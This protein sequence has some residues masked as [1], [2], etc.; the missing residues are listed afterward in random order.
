MSFGLCPTWCKRSFWCWKAM[1]QSTSYLLLAFEQCCTQQTVAS[2]TGFALQYCFRLVKS[3]LIQ[4]L[5]WAWSMKSLHTR[6]WALDVDV[7]SEQKQQTATFDERQK[8]IFIHC[9]IDMLHHNFCIP[10]QIWRPLEPYISIYIQ[11]L[12]YKMMMPFASFPFCHRSTHTQYASSS[13]F[14]ELLWLCRLFWTILLIFKIHFNLKLL[15]NV[16]KN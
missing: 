3:F 6:Y 7:E 4:S 2:T 10:S 15:L 9:S 16:Y 14:Y 13:S 12:Y 1:G 8:R 11:W 5:D